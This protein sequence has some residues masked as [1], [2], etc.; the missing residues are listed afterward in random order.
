MKNSNF[1]LIG[2]FFSDYIFVDV[3]VSE[4]LKGEFSMNIKYKVGAQ[5]ARK[6]TLKAHRV[7]GQ[8]ANNF[9]AKFMVPVKRECEL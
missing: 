2:K 3:I 7:E 4:K 8:R 6:I 1:L 9:G 5:K